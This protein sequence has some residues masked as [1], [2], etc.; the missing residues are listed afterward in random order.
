MCFEGFIPWSISFPIYEIWKDR[1]TCVFKA[2]DPSPIQVISY[3]ASGGAR[4]FMTA[5]VKKGMDMIVHSQFDHPLS[6]LM[7]H[8]DASFVGPNDVVWI[9]GIVRDNSGNWLLGFGKRVYTNTHYAAE[10]LAVLEA[11]RCVKSQGYQNAIIYSDCKNA[12]ELILGHRA[13]IYLNIL[14]P[15]RQWLRANLR[16]LIKHCNCQFNLVVDSMAK[17]CRSTEAACVL[18]RIFPTPPSTL[19]Y[20]TINSRL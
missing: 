14:I 5:S 17:V 1:N 2:K 15:C 11:M 16:I 12:V 13:H 20:S 8:V 4:D 10:L 7:I 6:C 19:L 3:Q 18:T 9:G